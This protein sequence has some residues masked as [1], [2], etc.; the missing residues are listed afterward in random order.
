DRESA[1]RLRE[2]PLALEGVV[3]L[4]N[5]PLSP[6][7]F[8]DVPQHC[9]HGGRG[10]QFVEYRLAGHVHGAHGAVRPGDPEFAVDGP[11]V[12]Q[13]VGHGGGQR[14]AVS[15][16]HPGRELVE[17]ERAVL[18]RTAEEPV[19]LLGPG[20]A[21]GE[22]VPLGAARAQRRTA[23]R[24]RALG[25]GGWYVV[26]GTRWAGWGAG[27]GA[28]FLAVPVAGG[29]GVVGRWGETFAQLVE[30][31]SEVVQLVRRQPAQG[32][33][34]SPSGARRGVVVLGFLTLRA[35]AHRVQV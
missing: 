9:P 2:V 16:D 8:A 10:A 12:D 32:A 3:C 23:G 6:A 20:D 35:V 28:G 27:G 30:V 4:A 7:Q 17:G 21:V 22:E 26:D 5:V 33:L 34:P 1:F 19:E 15:L 29:L 25:P 13:A 14:R 31:A 18:A 24:G 11:A